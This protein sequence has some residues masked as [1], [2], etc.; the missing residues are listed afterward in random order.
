MPT[1]NIPVLIGASLLVSGTLIAGLASADMDR[2]DHKDGHRGQKISA[3]K[4]DVNQDGMISMDEMLTRQ[5]NRFAKLDSN[6]DGAI[7]QSEFNARMV[8][9]FNRMDADGDGLLNDE[10]ISNSM[11]KHKR[12]GGYGKVRHGEAS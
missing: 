5:Q 2:G 10:E 4:L 7:D 8:V 6:G 9:M 11:Q 12:G 1:K 3:K